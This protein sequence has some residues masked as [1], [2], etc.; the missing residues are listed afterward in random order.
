FSI[1]KA[2]QTITFGTLGNKTYG[3]A[4]FALTATSSSNL[5]V[6]YAVGATDNCTVSGSTV[7]ITGAGACTVTAAQPGNANYNPAT[8]VPQTFSITKASQTITFSPLA[9]AVYGSTFTLAA[10]ASS[11]L[12][13]TYS[14]SSGSVC[15]LSATN[16]I[17]M[18]N[19]TGI[20]T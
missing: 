19:G 15:T 13:V 11:S 4:P 7:T 3:D 9:T 1:T 5:A 20:C 14:V 6:S 18:T 8:S 12:A 16:T 17:T 10:T 2:S